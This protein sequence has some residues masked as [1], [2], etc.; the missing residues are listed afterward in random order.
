MSFANPITASLILALSPE[1]NFTLHSA[2]ACLIAGIIFFCFGI[3]I[4]W[5]I[6]RHYQA[7]ALRVED[8]NQRL[9]REYENMEKA[10]RKLKDARS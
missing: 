4:G 5:K 10:Y 6:W 8:E 1:N 2:I 7:E 3:A 9:L